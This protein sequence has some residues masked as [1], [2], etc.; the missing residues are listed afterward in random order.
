M[1]N[2][3]ELTSSSQGDDS[4]PRK[5]RLLPS[6]GEKGVVPT[7]GIRR[8]DKNRWERR[9]PVAP[10][11]VKALVEKGVRVLIQPSSLRTFPDKQY[12]EVTYLAFHSFSSSFFFFLMF[13]TPLV[14]RLEHLY[15]KISLK[16]RRLFQ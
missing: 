14:G 16:H 10:K 2:K 7:L 15:K 11:H 9:A 1:Q 3:R 6:N 12:A 8:E 13:P 4:S 5:K